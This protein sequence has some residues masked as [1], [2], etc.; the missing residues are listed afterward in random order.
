MITVTDAD[1]MP[2]EGEK[3]KHFLFIIVPPCTFF[4]LPE[5]MTLDEIQ[6]QHWKRR[7]PMELFHLRQ[8]VDTPLAPLNPSPPEGDPL[9]PEIEGAGQ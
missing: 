2:D 8:P 3:T 9:E 5:T 6:M 7:Q 1:D 4:P